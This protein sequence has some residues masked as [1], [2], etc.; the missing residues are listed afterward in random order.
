MVIEVTK[1]SLKNIIILIIYFVKPFLFSAHQ[2]ALISTTAI[3]VYLAMIVIIKIYLH[4]RSNEIG[5]AIVFKKG[6]CAGDYNRAH[7]SNSLAYV[8]YIYTNTD[9]KYLGNII[10]NNYITHENIWPFVYFVSY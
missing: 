7:Y 4:T 3:T 6:S 1:N 8:A 5:Y 9:L 2:R 10:L